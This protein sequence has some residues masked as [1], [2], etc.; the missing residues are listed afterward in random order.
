V[1]LGWGKHR[2][3]IEATQ[4]DR[5]AALAVDAACDKALTKELLERAFIP[6]PRGVIARSREEAVAA[7]DGLRPPLAVKPL[8]GNQGRAVS[9]R[10]TTAEQVAAAFDHAAALSPSVVVEEFL[11]GRDYRVVVVDGRMVAAAERV[12]AHVVGDGSHTVTELIEIE[13]QSPRRGEGHEKPLTRLPLDDQTLACLSGAGRGLTDVPPAGERVFLRATANLS[14]GGTARDVTD[15]VHPVVAR[16]CERAAR[17]LGLDVCG[18]DLILPD[19]AEPVPEQGGGILEVNAAP[20]IRM[21]HHP[22]A[23]KPRDV[24][25][26]V[27][28]MLFPDDSDG[29][30]PVVAVTGTNGKTTVTRMVGHVLGTAG[31]VVGLTTTDGIHIGGHRVAT[32]DMTGL[33]SA[34]VVLSDPAVDVAVLETARGGIVRRGL[35]YDWADVAVLTNIQADHLGQDGI[36]TLEDVLWVKS[37]VAERV[38][39]GGTLVLN[40]DDE[41]LAALPDA[42]R[43]KKLRRQV[44]F[45]SLSEANPVVRAHRAGG[46][47]AFVLRDGW[48]VEAEGGREQRLV[49]AAA[50]PVTLGGRAHFQTANALAAA[51]ACGALGLAPEQVAFALCHFRSDWDN[52][53]RMNP[54][55]S[56]AATSWW[57]T[58]TTRVRSKPWAGWRSPGV[59]AGRRRSSPCPATGPT[60]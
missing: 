54:S 52:P 24:G 27:I 58:G 46:G 33:N 30:I 1:Q 11:E 50:L 15:D 12:P 53:G 38:R 32:G 59:T 25:A 49:E 2:R 8:D 10:L 60:R 16:L 29:R 18:I 19:I 48:L 9:L 7:L 37:L 36:D 57:T 56:S 40:A 47:T 6:V 39:V 5:T 14:T 26:A 17:V 31:Q 55:R 22:S 4:T 23:G 13:N 35:G 20:G 34:R 45:F 51:A 43:V 42:P 41:R 21:H 3:L 44:V 28:N